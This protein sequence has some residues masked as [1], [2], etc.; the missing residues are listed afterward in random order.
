MVILPFFLCLLNITVIIKSLDVPF[1]RIKL[2]HEKN[3]ACVS[4]IQHSIVLEVP[5]DVDDN[6]LQ[7]ALQAFMK[8]LTTKKSGLKAVHTQ[9]IEGSD[10]EELDSTSVNDDSPPKG[11]RGPLPV[12]DNIPPNPRRQTCAPSGSDAL[13]EAIRAC[14]D[15]RE[16]LTA[17]AKCEDFCPEDIN[18]RLLNTMR[19]NFVTNYIHSQVFLKSYIR[20][21]QTLNGKGIVYDTALLKYA[22]Y[23]S[24]LGYCHG[25]SG[26]RTLCREGAVYV[27]LLCTP[28]SVWCDAHPTCGIH[29]QRAFRKLPTFQC[30]K[31]GEISYVQNAVN[32]IIHYDKTTAEKST[33]ENNLPGGR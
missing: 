16:L 22:G 2:A 18:V 1:A 32:N 30:Y 20:T 5:E 17:R 12:S 23:S 24:F 13:K 21:Y 9:D 6:V 10:G 15:C 29:K 11:F 31:K 33:P 25:I 4:T 14:K 3:T 27:C 7:T 26:K 19:N 28:V 8:S